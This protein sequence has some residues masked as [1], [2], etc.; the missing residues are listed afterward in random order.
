MW[1]ARLKSLTLIGQ[2]STREAKP[3]PNDVSRS[4]PRQCAQGNAL[5]QLCL[6]N[7]DGIVEVD[8]LDGVQDAN[9][10][11]HRALEGFTT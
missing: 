2:S 6:C 4:R 3:T 9:T 11:F 7:R 8:V 1:A 5:K 10:F